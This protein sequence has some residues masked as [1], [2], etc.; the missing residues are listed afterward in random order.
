MRSIIVI[1]PLF[2]FTPLVQ[3]EKIQEHTKMMDHGGGHFMDMDGGMVMGQNVDRIPDGCSGIA[4]EEEITVRAGRKYAKNFPGRIYAF[5]QQEFQF[6]PCTKLTVHFINEDS[7]RHQ[8]MMH[9]LP[10]YLYQKGMFHLEVTGPGKISGTLILPPGE[11]TYL[12]HCDIAQHMEKGMK[13]QLKTGDGKGDL[14]SIPGLTSYINPD[15]FD[16]KLIGD[17]AS[18]EFTENLASYG[19][20]TS[21]MQPTKTKRSWASGITVIGIA[22]GILLMSLLIKKFRGM[23]PSEIFEYIMGL[24]KSLLIQTKK[25]LDQIIKLSIEIFKAI[26][27]KLNQKTS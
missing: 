24:I 12:V 4:D 11:Q 7:I 21:S 18:A 8:W 16:P 10:K 25:L 27:A 23:K 6:E 19:A 14:P 22:V 15:K 17:N 26:Q 13:G 3:A 20:P 2:L 1:L 9:G 5:D